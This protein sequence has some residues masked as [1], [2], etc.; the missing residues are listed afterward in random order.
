[1]GEW[2]REVNERR[3]GYG[4]QKFDFRNNFHQKHFQVL[5]HEQFSFL[6]ANRGKAK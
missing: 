5:A 3:G 1:M 4:A 2:A 6:R